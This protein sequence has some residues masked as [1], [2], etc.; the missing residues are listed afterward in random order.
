MKKTN[1]I[2]ELTAIV[3]KCEKLHNRRDVYRSQQTLAETV[4]QGY[5]VALDLMQDAVANKNKD[6]FGAVYHLSNR[7]MPNTSNHDSVFLDWLSKYKTEFHKKVVEMISDDYNFILGP[8]VRSI[9]RTLGHAKSDEQKEAITERLNTIYNG[10]PVYF[11]KEWLN[12]GKG[13]K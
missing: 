4:K 1:K 9:K 8:K 3:S 5:E 6:I 12:L 7:L 10:F 11:S 13:S 2:D